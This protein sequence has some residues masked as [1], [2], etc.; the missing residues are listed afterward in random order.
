M[1]ILLAES[2]LLFGSISIIEEIVRLL[3]TPLKGGTVEVTRIHHL[4]LLLQVFL[5]LE[6]LREVALA[7][8]DGLGE[9]H[10][11]LVH[12]LATLINTLVVILPPAPVTAT[13]IPLLRTRR[14]EQLSVFIEVLFPL[15]LQFALSEL[16]FLLFF[17]VL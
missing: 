9:T 1:T 3:A 14:L 11:R 12:L 2:N 7:G 8:L 15:P 17:Q 5:L 6:L 13:E 10:F 4:G 16:L